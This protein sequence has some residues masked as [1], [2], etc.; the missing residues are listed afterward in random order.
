MLKD[1]S[2]IFDIWETGQTGLGHYPLCKL[3]DHTCSQ[4]PYAASVLSEF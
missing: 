4:P 1:F 2:M 3:T